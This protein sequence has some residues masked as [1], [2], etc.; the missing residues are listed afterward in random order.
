MD[1][2]TLSISYKYTCTSTGVTRIR[3]TPLYSPL[4]RLEIFFGSQTASNVP[5]YNV[6]MNDMVQLRYSV[7]DKIGGVHGFGFG[8]EQ[9]NPSTTNLSPI[10]GTAMT[11]SG[12]D[13]RVLQANEVGTFYGP[14][15]SILSAFDKFIPLGMMPQVRVQLTLDSI[16]NIFSSTPVAA[17]DGFSRS[18]P[19]Q[20]ATTGALSVDFVISDAVLQYVHVDMGPEVDSSVRA[21]GDK[22]VIK[23]E[24][25]TSSAN[26]RRLHTTAPE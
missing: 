18:T 23:T 7:A 13:G 8:L 6:T 9:T 16:A 4:Q 14:L 17:N 22:I 24:S 11:L 20:T 10:T 19:L 15:P 25:F 26:L 21:M 12:C 3:C 2:C 5:N 1:G